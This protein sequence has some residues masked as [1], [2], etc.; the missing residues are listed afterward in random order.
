[1]D[2]YGCHNTVTLCYIEESDTGWPCGT[3]PAFV[4]SV[5]IER[6][7]CWCA[8]E[9]T[10]D[11]IKSWHHGTGV[12]VRVRKWTCREGYTDCD[13]VTHAPT[14]VEGTGYWNYTVIRSKCVVGPC[15]P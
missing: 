6:H 13:Q 10:E 8:E 4:A 15:Y 5:S 14:C 1:M 9:T 12:N 11:K 7:R 3:P 2:W